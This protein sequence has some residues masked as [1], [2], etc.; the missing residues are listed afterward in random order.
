[1]P[2]LKYSKKDF[3]GFC[4]DCESKN[5]RQVYDFI[6]FSNISFRAIREY[7]VKNEKIKNGHISQLFYYFS[8]QK[9]YYMKLNKKES[10][11]KRLEIENYFKN[12]E[13]EIF[14]DLSND[15][16]YTLFGSNDFYINFPEVFNKTFRDCI[17]ENSE[18]TII[19]QLENIL[20]IKE[21]MVSE[22]VNK[23]I[24]LKLFITTKK[25][26]KYNELETLK[27][28]KAILNVDEECFT[29]FLWWAKT[30]E[31]LHSFVQDKT[32]VSSV[33]SGNYK[34]AFAQDKTLVSSVLSGS[35]KQDK[36][37]MSDLSLRDKQMFAFLNNLDAFYQ[38]ITANK[39]INRT[40]KI[41]E[42]FRMLSP[43]IDIFFKNI[44]LIA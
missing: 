29:S 40:I 22:L 1:M 9:D 42:G 17:Q 3:V 2:L 41:K 34:Q 33:L 12:R 27:N 32:L 18:K 19:F 16:K 35:Y 15:E 13:L 44:E 20:L 43:D 8:V 37:F 5:Q 14:N 21:E 4:L 7:M 38:I 28:R 31:R 10:F 6:L 23:G 11:S 36:V 26:P 39:G 24:I 30:N 25:V